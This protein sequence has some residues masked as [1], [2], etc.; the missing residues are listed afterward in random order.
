MNKEKEIKNILNRMMVFEDIQTCAFADGGNIISAD[1]RYV[2]I[3][4]FELWETFKR[5]IDAFFKV[6]RTF[7]GYNMNNITFELSEYEVILSF[8]GYDMALITI[9]TSL[10]N[11]GLVDVEIETTRRDIKKLLKF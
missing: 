9:I 4:N 8:I 2:K 10:A 3:K 1:E 11:K 6:Y 5:T 7:S